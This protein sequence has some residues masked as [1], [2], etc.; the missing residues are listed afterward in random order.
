MVCWQCFIDVVV[1]Q[2]YGQNG[3]PV[4]GHAELANALE[5]VLRAYQQSA[6]QRVQ[7]TSLCRKWKPPCVLCRCAP[8]CYLLL[9]LVFLLF[10]AFSTTVTVT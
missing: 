10:G 1:Q 5:F 7:K 6:D 4:V 8:V 9:F 2:E 3:V